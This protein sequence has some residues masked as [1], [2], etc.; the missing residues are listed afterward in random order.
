MKN[1]GIYIHIPFCK[2]KCSYCD[3]ISFASKEECVNEYIEAVKKEIENSNV[4]NYEIDTIYIGGGTPSFISSK[5]ILQIL[6]VIKNRFILKK[7]IEI[8]IEVN[9]G[10]VNKGKLDDYFK[11]GINRISI[12]LQST[13][14]DILKQL[15]RIHSYEDFLD[16]YNLVKQVGFKN[17]NVDLMLALPNQTLK[18]LNESVDEIINLKPEHI[19]IY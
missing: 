19:S 13:K 15:G 12:G 18:D 14:N 11:S 6:D 1:L 9:P 5:Y 4:N 2:Q 10:T 3:F 17:I 16:K 8:T 7:N